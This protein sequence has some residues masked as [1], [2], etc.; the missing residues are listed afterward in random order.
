[1]WHGRDGFL[2]YQQN[3]GL[4][5]E[6]ESLSKLLVL[7]SLLCAMENFDDG[8]C[9]TRTINIEDKVFALYDVEGNTIP[10]IFKDNPDGWEKVKALPFLSSQDVIE[11]DEHLN[12][13]DLAYKL[14]QVENYCE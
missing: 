10:L 14:I 5:V 4:G 3:S 12:T 8:S 1:M 7:G 11:L 6:T 13:Q 2:A 9:G